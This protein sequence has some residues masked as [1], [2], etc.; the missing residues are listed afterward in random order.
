MIVNLFSLVAA[1]AF[2]QTLPPGT[3]YQD[4]VYTVRSPE[5]LRDGRWSFMIRSWSDGFIP[6]S[7]WRGECLGDEIEIAAERDEAGW[8]WSLSR[9]SVEYPERVIAVFNAETD[10]RNMTPAVR[11]V[12]CNANGLSV[13]LRSIDSHV[14]PG[15]QA[16]EP[17]RRTTVYE[18]I[19]ATIWI[20][21]DQATVRLRQH[22]G[23]QAIGPD[24]LRER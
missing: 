17:D 7:I 18:I 2:A 6:T 5:P 1:L 15:F 11:S 20:D 9:A 19:D 23:G 24:D 4:G 12:D 14:L 10:D 22:I 8:Q 3:E 21:N 13:T 16:E